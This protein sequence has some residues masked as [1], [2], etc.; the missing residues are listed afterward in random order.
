M[1]PKAQSEYAKAFCGKGF[2]K[3]NFIIYLEF[4]LKK[5]GLMKTPTTDKT[6]KKPFEI[7]MAFLMIFIVIARGEAISFSQ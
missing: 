7:R 1:A 3:T 6:P 2:L 5:S 4:K